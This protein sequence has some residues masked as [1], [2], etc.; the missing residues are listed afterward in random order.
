MP[1]S[2]N[3]TLTHSSKLG[4]GALDHET[5]P[6]RLLKILL[7]VATTDEVLAQ[8]HMTGHMFPRQ[9]VGIGDSIRATASK[10]ATCNP[11]KSCKISVFSLR[12]Q[13]AVHL[14]WTCLGG[15]NIFKC[16]GLMTLQPRQLIFQ[17]TTLWET[18]S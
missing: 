10:K 15:L 16:N 14:A 1:N 3:H 9:F 2:R 12:D 5:V 17:P 13:S 8:L 6:P 4:V 7:C 18:C 11:W